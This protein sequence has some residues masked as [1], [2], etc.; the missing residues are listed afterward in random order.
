LVLVGLIGLGVLLTAFGIE[1]RIRV[2]TRA[3]LGMVGTSLGVLLWWLGAGL[4]SWWKR[5]G[6]RDSQGKPLG[7][8]QVPWRKL[9]LVFAPLALAVGFGLG[10]KWGYARAYD[11]CQ[12]ALDGEDPERIA[13]SLAEGEA[14]LAAP[15]LIVPHEMVDEWAPSR[16]ED[17]REKLGAPR[18]PQAG[19]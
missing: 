12:R 10:Q 14:L 6:E 15:W 2:L 18:P 5:D 13:A 11:P 1:E 8:R 17:A 16:C 9:G 19:L 3:G 7:S 4:V